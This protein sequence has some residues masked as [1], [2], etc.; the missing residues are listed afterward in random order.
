MIDKKENPFEVITFGKFKG[1][2]I[3]EIPDSYMKWFISIP[4]ISIKASAYR[5]K[6]ITELRRRNSFNE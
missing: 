6:F 1:K 2:M 5:Q 3:S 4:E